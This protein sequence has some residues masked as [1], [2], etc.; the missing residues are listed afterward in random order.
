MK[1]TGCKVGATGWVFEDFPLKLFEQLASLNSSVWLGVVVKQ[2]N[3]RAKY[4]SSFV[5]N[6]LP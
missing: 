5:L 6:C 1:V 2:K 4:A 3:S